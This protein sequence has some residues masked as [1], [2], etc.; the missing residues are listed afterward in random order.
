MYPKV[1]FDNLK[2]LYDAQIPLLHVCGSLDPLL[3]ENS[4]RLE[5]NYKKLGGHIT[6]ILKEGVGHYPLG[7]NDPQPVIN[8]IAS[9]A[10]K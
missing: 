6:V 8:F 4:Q 10:G 1:S 9:A 2:P 7:P 5:Q 3:K